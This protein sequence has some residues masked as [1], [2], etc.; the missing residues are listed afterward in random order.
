MT[1]EELREKD[2]DF[3]ASL[4][5]SK[6]NNML[7]KIYN[8]ITLNELDTVKHFL[9]E[10]A[11]QKI[12]KK[13]DDVVQKGNHLIY[14]EVNVSSGIRNI[15]E[16]EDYY[17]IEVYATIKYLEYIKSNDGRIVSG[18]DLDRVTTN[19]RVLLR[20]IKKTIDK[21]NYYRCLGCGATLDINDNGKCS[22]CGRIFD[23][24][25][26]DYIIDSIE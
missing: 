9:S 22:H 8:A 14:E 15:D 11:F 4:F 18:N 2:Q 16:D 25:E 17:R 1:L 10:S 26:F 19:K 20:K 21:K 5:I 12:Q 24:E 6:V 13:N 23:L 3:N 7:K